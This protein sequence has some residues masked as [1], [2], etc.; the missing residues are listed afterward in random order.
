MMAAE[1]ATSTA[2]TLAQLI[3]GD[4]TPKKA[5]FTA[6]VVGTILI[7]INYGD[8]VHDGHWP[9]LWKVF[10]TYCTPYCVTTWGAVIGKR[11]QWRHSLQQRVQESGRPT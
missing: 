5:F 7:T 3:L 9:P 11:S 2:P 6:A 10:L 4:G 8:T 1:A